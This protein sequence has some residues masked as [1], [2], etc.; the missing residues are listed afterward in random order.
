[1][2]FLAPAYAHIE[3]TLSI[4]SHR[5]GINWEIKWQTIAPGGFYSL[6]DVD[7]NQVLIF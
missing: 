5:L 6:H 1:M 7:K 3:A 2:D 4:A